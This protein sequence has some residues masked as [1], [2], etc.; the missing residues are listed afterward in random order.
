MCWS[1]E[2][3]T[4]L[5]FVAFSCARYQLEIICIDVAWFFVYI[6]GE[7]GFLHCSFLSWEDQL[8]VIL[9]AKVNA[10]VIRYFI[11]K[12]DRVLRLITLRIVSCKVTRLFIDKKIVL[13]LKAHQDSLSKV[14]GL[15][16]PH[17]SV[18]WSP[19]KFEPL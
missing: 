17:G 18:V 12:V 2:F 3:F 11:K 16:N 7:D 5:I 8:N 14:S 10:C 9:L 1:W 6:Y 15:P 19:R 13:L 4:S